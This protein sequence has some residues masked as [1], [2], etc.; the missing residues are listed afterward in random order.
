[1]PGVFGQGQ[2]STAACLLGAQDSRR[3]LPLLPLKRHGTLAAADARTQTWPH[4]SANWSWFYLRAGNFTA[5]LY[6]EDDLVVPWPVM[7][8]WAEDAELLHVSSWSAESCWP[9][10][11]N[12]CLQ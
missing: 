5:F 12:P 4:R 2:G 9:S 3:S 7:Q 11:W 8:A 10:Q 6:L 1:M